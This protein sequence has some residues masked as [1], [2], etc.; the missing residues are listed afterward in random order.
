MGFSRR[1]YWSGLPCLPPG[2]IPEPGIEPTSL[3]SPALAGRLFTT[4]TTQKAHWLSLNNLPHHKAYQGQS[5]DLNPGWGRPLSHSTRLLPH[6][7]L[8]TRE[9]GKLPYPFFNICNFFAKKVKDTQSCPT[10]CDSM[11]CIVHGILQAKILEWVAFHFSRGSSQPT[12]WT[13][14]CKMIHNVHAFQRRPGYNTGLMER[15]LGKGLRYTA[16]GFDLHINTSWKD[17][18][19]K[20]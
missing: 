14:L 2:D 19:N 18:H 4:S 17:Y 15:V 12:D 11:D 6:L 7:L 9:S 13:L 1:K 16:S 10:L 3:M 8:L 20:V 5:W